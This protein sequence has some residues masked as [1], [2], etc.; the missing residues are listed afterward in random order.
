MAKQPP[1]YNA[2]QRECLRAAARFNSQLLDMVRPHVQPGVQTGHIDRL[3]YEYTMDHGHIPAC[4][5]YNGPANAPPYPR[6]SCI[7]IN[8]IVCHGIPGKRELVDGDIA[9]VDLTTIVNGWHGDQ[10]E[11][12]LIGDVS[13][14]V[15]HLVQTTFDSMWI[16]IRAIR[17][18]GRVRD[19]GAAIYAYAHEHSL[20]V[21]REFQ[22]HGIGRSFHQEPGIP[23]FWFKGRKE[24]AQVIRPGVCFTIEPMLNQG[25]WRTKVS[26]SDGW[27][28][29]TADGRLSAQFE[30]QILM[31]EDGP[32]VL[33]VTENGPQEGHK[34]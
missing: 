27:T 11:T 5:G 31:T 24:G 10:S 8:E 9:N 34:F 33:T 23:H 13:D 18:F 28:V 32:E 21:V 1:I 15:R 30:H 2:E 14:E 19:I 12:F 17:P 22:G 16:G 29:R 7:S 25:T 6:S 20:E 3:V 26:K 4:L